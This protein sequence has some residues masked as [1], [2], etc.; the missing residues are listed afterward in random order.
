VKSISVSPG[1]GELNILNFKAISSVLGEELSER[2][3][4]LEIRNLR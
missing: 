3:A 1:Q 4:R 2:D